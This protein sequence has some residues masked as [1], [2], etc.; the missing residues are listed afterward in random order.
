MQIK[1]N[2]AYVLSF[3]TVTYSCS[4]VNR[5]KFQ[6]VDHVRTWAIYFILKSANNRLHGLQILDERITTEL[7]TKKRHVALNLVDL[8]RILNHKTDLVDRTES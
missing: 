5:H 1:G 3:F 4:L 8:C 6:I 2:A 7:F